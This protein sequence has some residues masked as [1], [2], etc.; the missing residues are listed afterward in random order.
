MYD[1]LKENK[2]LSI[3]QIS[4]KSNLP[5]SKVSSLLLNL[6]FSGLVI[7]MPGKIY[8]ISQ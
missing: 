6:E 8:K 3:D 2:E 1:L 4:L 7:S 5:M